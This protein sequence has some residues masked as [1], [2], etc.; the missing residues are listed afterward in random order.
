MI[1]P[2]ELK[3]R[4]ERFGK[5]KWWRWGDV[6]GL[7]KKEPFYEYEEISQDVQGKVLTGD[8]IQLF[9]ERENER[10]L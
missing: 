7:G 10:E 6:F 8:I 4:L 2:E 9:K 5:E 3:E 1:K